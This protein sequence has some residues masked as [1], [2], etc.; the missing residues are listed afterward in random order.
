M[1]NPA[2]PEPL[3]T[4]EETSRLIE[5]IARIRGEA[6][7]VI[8]MAFRDAML[9]AGC[10]RQLVADVIRAAERLATRNFQGLD[11]ETVR[12]ATEGII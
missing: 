8:V 6:S 1:T 12:I 9:A 2:S 10:R 7:S 5:L 3:M 4:D 11:A